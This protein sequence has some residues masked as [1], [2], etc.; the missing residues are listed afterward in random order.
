MLLTHLPRLANRCL[1]WNVDKS[2]QDSAKHKQTLKTDLCQCTIVFLKKIVYM[3]PTFGLLYCLRPRLFKA[4]LQGK[5]LATVVA[6]KVVER[7]CRR[8]GETNKKT[9]ETSLKDSN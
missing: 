2:L 9:L 8:G 5:P 4:G 6:G 3:N 7:S 1:Y